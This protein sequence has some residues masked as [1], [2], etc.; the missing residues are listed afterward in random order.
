M[1]PGKTDDGAYKFG[2]QE[3]YLKVCAA[4]KANPVYRRVFFSGK[5]CP[6]NNKTCAKNYAN[7]LINAESH[8]RTTEHANFKAEFIFIAGQVSKAKVQLF[9]KAYGKQVRNAPEVVV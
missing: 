1:K 7:V 4:T 3:F 2:C 9:H 6:A 5:S 8:G